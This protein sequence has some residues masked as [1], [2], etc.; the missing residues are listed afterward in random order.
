MLLFAN[1]PGQQAVPLLSAWDLSSFSW[2]QRGTVQDMMAFMAKTVSER[3]SPAQR[4]SIQENNFTAHV[5]A[6]PAVDGVSGVLIS[7]GEYPVRVAYSLLSKLLDE[8]LLKVPKSTWQAQAAQLASSGA[9]PSK[10]EGIVKSSDFPY[11]QDYLSRY[12]DPRQADTILRV[13]QELDDTKIVLVRGRPPHTAQ[14]HRLGAAARRGPRQA[15]REER[16]AE[17]A[18][19]DVLQVGSQGTC[20]AALTRSKVRAPS[21]SPRRL[22]LRRHVASVPPP[23]MPHGPGAAAPRADDEI[24]ALFRTHSVRELEAVAASLVQQRRDKQDAVRAQAGAHVP[25]LLSMSHTVV[26]MHDSAAALAA[27]VH[28]LPGALHTMAA[29]HVQRADEAGAPPPARHALRDDRRV[30]A[31]CLLVADAPALVRASLATQAYLRAAWACTT[32]DRAAAWLQTH[33][34]AAWARFP[35]VATQHALCAPLRAEALMRTQTWLRR[36]DTSLATLLDA[37]VAWM[38]LRGPAATPAWQQ[39]H[40]ERLDA[41]VGGCLQPRALSERLAELVHGV[42][43]TL[44]QTARIWGRGGAVARL[45]QAWRDDPE[46]W[47]RLGADA[48]RASLYAPSMSDLYGC[49]DDAVR[50]MDVPSDLAQ[51]VDVEAV[52]DELVARLCDELDSLAADMVGGLDM[53]ALDAARGALERALGAAQH[54]A[55]LRPLSQRLHA[56]LDARAQQLWHD[57]LKS[58]LGAFQTQLDVVVAH[59]S[60]HDRYGAALWAPAESDAPR[61]RTPWPPA[62]VACVDTLECGLARLAGAEASPPASAHHL[63]RD[64]AER[65]AQ[66]PAQTVPQL[67]AVYQLTTALHDRRVLAQCAGAAWS[68]RLAEAQRATAERWAAALVDDVVRARWPW[69]T[70]M[71]FLAAETQA[72][73]PS[74]VP[75]PRVL[76]QVRAVRADAAPWLDADT[77]PAAR[78]AEAQAWRTSLVPWTQPSAPAAALGARRARRAVPPFVAW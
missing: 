74:F 41:A 78:S 2:M 53:D 70:T 1:Q 62:I 34:A 76:D 72:L 10:G 77:P 27:H 15:R 57:T 56:M 61:A 39:W 47:F 55:A 37:L 8:F 59:A 16:L 23:A 68:T 19:Q 31:A 6:R 52:G 51:D 4:Q 26:A 66:A 75:P 43:T 73:G 5:H 69:R 21:P 54:G 11:A 50:H 28:A 30:A 58:V 35:L 20:A 7:D 63:C 32:A 3:T 60:E 46:L 13:Q 14:H 42:S 67:R 9:I 65:L 18:E 36:G 44:E 71:L 17:P 24:E 22:V 33:D 25:Q 64:V 12:Q 38:M 48:E 29:A 40:T 45:R 49:A